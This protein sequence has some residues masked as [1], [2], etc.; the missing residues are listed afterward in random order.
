VRGCERGTIRLIFNVQ[1]QNLPRIN[2][3]SLHCATCNAAVGSSQG[4]EG[5]FRLFKSRLALKTSQDQEAQEFPP[6]VFICSQLLSLIES[7]V[8]RKI[9]LHCE[10]QGDIENGHAGLLLWIFNPDIYYSSSS[11]GPTVHRAMKVFY[12]PLLEIGKFLDEHSNTH[13]ELTVP[14]EDLEDFRKTLSDS[15]AILPQSAR[16]FQDWGVGLIDRWE[17]NATGASWMDQNPLNKKVDEGFETFKL[18][19]GMQ[20]LYL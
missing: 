7:S 9:V 12:Q 10:T 2:G 18:P 17:K 20:E 19:E 16:S 5:N 13:E 3:T 8:T 15:T 6:S 11:R 1:E 14:P 4:D